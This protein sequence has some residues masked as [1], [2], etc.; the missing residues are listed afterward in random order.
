VN[1]KIYDS[2]GGFDEGFPFP[3]LEDTDFYERLKLVAKTTFLENAKVIHPWRRPRKWSNY[4][5]WIKCHEHAIKKS[6]TSKNMFYRVKRVNLFIGLL[7]KNGFKLFKYKFKG[8]NFYVEI[9][10]CNFILIFK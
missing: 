1:K 6:N 10:L 5:K 2:I 7:I 8:V 3:A 9:S 4:K